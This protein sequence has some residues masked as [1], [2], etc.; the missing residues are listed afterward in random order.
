MEVGEEWWKK[1][2]YERMRE[3]GGD[4]DLQVSVDHFLS[5]AVVDTVKYLLHTLA[6]GSDTRHI[7]RH[8]HTSSCQTHIISK[9]KMM[10]NIST[11]CKRGF[12]QFHISPLLPDNIQLYIGVINFSKP[13]PNHQD[14][15]ST[16][17]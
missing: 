3:A 2:M 4:T 7:T 10:S 17:K 15:P 8:T 5:V 16:K 1:Q 11:R 12:L 9:T 6:V 14:L 13:T